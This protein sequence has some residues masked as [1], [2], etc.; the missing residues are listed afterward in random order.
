MGGAGLRGQPADP[1]RLRADR[2]AAEASAWPV[3]GAGAGAGKGAVRGRGL[4]AAEGAGAASAAK[5]TVEA[6]GGVA[7][8]DHHEARIRS[9][10][11]DVPQLDRVGSL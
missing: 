3:R 1:H 9:T 2:F 7:E 11:F 4:I 6:K 5:A 8:K 10:T